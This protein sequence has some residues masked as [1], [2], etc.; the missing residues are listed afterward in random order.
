MELRLL[1][2][3]P[4]FLEAIMEKVVLTQ[5]QFALKIGTTQQ[6]ISNYTSGRQV[7]SQEKSELIIDYALYHA[8]IK[9]NDYCLGFEGKAAVFRKLEFDKCPYRVKKLMMRISKLHPRKRRSILDTMEAQ[10]DYEEKKVNNGN[11]KNRP[12]TVDG[13]NT[14]SEA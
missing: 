1:I 14:P 6:T 7:P 11:S 10:L 13:E 2:D 5:E 3:W 12:S 8:E 4:K 9:Y